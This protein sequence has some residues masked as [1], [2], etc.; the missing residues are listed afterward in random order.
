MASIGTGTEES[1]LSQESIEGEI[2][3]TEDKENDDVGCGAIEF[4][5]GVK[6]K[7]VAVS[8]I[9]KLSEEYIAAVCRIE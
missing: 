7:I 6:G 2:S 5:E 4:W 8:N 1:K 9:V 3:E